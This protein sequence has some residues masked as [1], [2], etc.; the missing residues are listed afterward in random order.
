[1]KHKQEK[2]YYEK[3]I[4]SIEETN[5]KLS[6]LSKDVSNYSEYCRTLELKVLG[7]ERK[8]QELQELHK[9]PL[10]KLQATREK[11][12]DTVN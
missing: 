7:L 11:T 10:N 2:K 3:T 6:K 9:N 8:V 5:R 4:A 12:A 1:M